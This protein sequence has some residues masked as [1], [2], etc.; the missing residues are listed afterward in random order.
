MNE[1]MIRDAYCKIRTIDQTIPDDVLDFMKDA[2]IEKLNSQSKEEELN[3]LRLTLIEI[4]SMM[5]EGK[6]K[7]ALR[8]VTLDELFKKAFELIKKNKIIHV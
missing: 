8:K 2:S 7:T 5:I 4:K 6:P 3:T 1:K